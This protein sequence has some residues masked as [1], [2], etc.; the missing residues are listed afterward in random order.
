MSG[1]ILIG[2]V[3]ETFLLRHHVLMLR[4]AGHSIEAFPRD[5]VDRHALLPRSMEKLMKPLIPEIPA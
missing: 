5:L 3:A 1:D 2:A 4:L